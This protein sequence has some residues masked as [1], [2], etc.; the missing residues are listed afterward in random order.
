MTRVQNVTSDQAP[1]APLTHTYRQLAVI[2]ESLAEALDTDTDLRS[3]T[4]E[5][6]NTLL[7][8]IEHE[9]DAQEAKVPAE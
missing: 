1:D 5:R 8:Y 7:K 2:H 9:L 6:V 4:L 3:W